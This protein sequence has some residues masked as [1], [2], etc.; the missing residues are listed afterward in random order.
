MKLIGS[1][2]KGYQL[3]SSFAQPK[4]AKEK[5]PKMN[6]SSPNPDGKEE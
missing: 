6:S 5:P 3:V 4:T 1:K 2:E